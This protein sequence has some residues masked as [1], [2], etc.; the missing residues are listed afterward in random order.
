MDA[1]RG[2]EGGGGGERE[3]ERKRERERESPVTL[4][5]N[6]EIRLIEKG[7]MEG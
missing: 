2:D 1:E 5:A 6:R 7:V 3:R 4:T